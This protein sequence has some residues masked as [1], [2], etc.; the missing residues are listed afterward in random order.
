MFVNETT[1]FPCAYNGTS[2]I[3]SW[4]INNTVYD[5]LHLP[6]NHFLSS[7]ENGIQLCV[8]NVQAN[9]NTTS[10]QCAF[11]H[12]RAWS[13]IG[14]LYVGKLNICTSLSLQ[15]QETVVCMFTTF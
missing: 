12:L 4:I 11:L 1:G 13:A 15:S 14:I 6:R 8:Y 10:Y 9:I 2:Q 5:I 7:I 3:P